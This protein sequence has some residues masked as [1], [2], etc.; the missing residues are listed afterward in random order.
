MQ[1]IRALRSLGRVALAVAAFCVLPA[2]AQDVANGRSIY[3]G[4]CIACH[5]FPPGGGP[6]RAGGNPALIQNAINGRVPA[7][8]FLRGVLSA[9]D[10]NDVA[11]YLLN[12]T[13]TP[14]PP[15]PP[16]PPPP[17]APAVPDWDVTDLWWNPAEP[18]WG[19]N[20]IQHATHQVFGV[21]YT[22]DVTRKP[23][24]LVM[25][26]GTWIASNRF[27]GDLYRVTGPQFNAP[28]FDPNRVD[29]RP[30]GTFRLDFGSRDS[31]TFSYTVSGVTYAK[32]IT[33][34]PF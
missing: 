20:L 6:D 8:G 16:P 17:P 34:Q 31:G 1:I 2:A 13:S 7:M 12:P 30:I 11:Q 25:P 22:Y 19:L 18:G 23:L 27:E 24:W 32:P 14:D 29:V 33:R 5:G 3:M 21:M 28:T 15:P 9:S 10:I 26:G 4:I